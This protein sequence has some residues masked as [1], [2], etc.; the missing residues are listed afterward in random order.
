[1]L[2]AV[3]C[4]GV[5]EAVAPG[6]GYKGGGRRL[7]DRP[8][9]PLET[10]HYLKADRGQRGRAYDDEWPKKK[11]LMSRNA[12]LRPAS[13]APS[14]STASP[15]FFL[16]LPNCPSAVQA[17]TRNSIHRAPATPILHFA[18]HAVQPRQPSTL[19]T[20]TG[21]MDGSPG[22]EE[23]PEDG[24][25]VPTRPVPVV[26]R[27][28]DGPLVGSGRTGAQFHVALRFVRPKHWG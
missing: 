23:D 16:P 27:D 4:L 3:A 8:G 6:L 5:S 19:T 20:T 9:R 26:I 7:D 21:T 13:Q 10:A 22:E 24:A 12:P 28:A 2:W 15:P 25:G 18:V 11:R 1:M 14:P 17:S